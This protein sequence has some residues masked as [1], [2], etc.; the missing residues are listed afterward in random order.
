MREL[1]GAFKPPRQVMENLV[2][3]KWFEGVGED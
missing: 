3:K 1:V 2:V